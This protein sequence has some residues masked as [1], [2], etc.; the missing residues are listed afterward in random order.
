MKKVEL[1][2]KVQLSHDE[3]ADQA[4]ARTVT[5]P[6]CLSASVLTICQ[7]I[8]HTPRSLPAKPRQRSAAIHIDDPS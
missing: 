8:D 2:L 6:E 1:D 4:M 3:T 7:N 5:N